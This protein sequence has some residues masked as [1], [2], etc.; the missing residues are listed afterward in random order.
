MGSEN[1]HGIRAELKRSVDLNQQYREEDKSY[2]TGHNLEFL[3][4]AEKGQWLLV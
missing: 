1:L 3:F 2:F 4:P